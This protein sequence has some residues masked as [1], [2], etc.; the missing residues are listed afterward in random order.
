MFTTYQLQFSRRSRAG[1]A[2]EERKRAASATA[3]ASVYLPPPKG[4]RQ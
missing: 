1:F 3:T 2:S 4:R